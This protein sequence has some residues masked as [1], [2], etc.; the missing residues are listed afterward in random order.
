MPLFTK[1][2]E[3][4][5][6]TNASAGGDIV[7]GNKTD[8]YNDNRT[9][10]NINQPANKPT[11]AQ[12]TL[13]TKEF[14]SLLKETSR[15]L[16]ENNN[17]AEGRLLTYA[18]TE[19]NIHIPDIKNEVTGSSQSLYNSIINNQKNYSLTGCGGSGKTFMIFDCIKQLLDKQDQII[20]FYIP[21]HSFNK[22]VENTNELLMQ[23]LVSQLSLCDDKQLKSWLKEKR[24][25]DNPYPLLFL[26]GFNEITNK[27]LEEKIINE[28]RNFQKIY[29]RIRFVIS[30][31]YDLSSK[32]TASGSGEL[33]F[34]QCAV[35]KLDN[36]YVNKYIRNIL[37]KKLEYSDEKINSHLNN[38]DSRYRKVS[39]HLWLLQCM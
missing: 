20:P 25:N 12:N 26:D 7:A 30:S 11:E 6:I 24:V 9:F 10:I 21:L 37:S 32:F 38:I 29:P 27:S 31:R 34:E 22:S 39:Q 5:T 15:T 8:I 17:R 23:Y 35:K 2:K 33:Y 16:Y 18:E 36:I 3:S 28:V 4:T 19:C 1:N 13:S 14:V